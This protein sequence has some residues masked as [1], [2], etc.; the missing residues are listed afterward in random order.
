MRL[1]PQ[2]HVLRELLLVASLIEPYRE[3]PGPGGLWVVRGGPW[4]RASLV[5]KWPQEERDD[6]LTV[7]NVLQRHRLFVTGNEEGPL[8]GLAREYSTNLEGDTIMMSA[9]LEDLNH[10]ASKQVWR[11]LYVIF[12]GS[13]RLEGFLT[14]SKCAAGRS[15]LGLASIFA[16]TSC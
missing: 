13:F 5:A 14:L 15:A 8:P 4:L 16:R 10:P 6:L 3:G 1:V 12:K 7:R 9:G 2:P 11:D